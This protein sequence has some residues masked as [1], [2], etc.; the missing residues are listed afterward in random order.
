MLPTKTYTILEKFSKNVVITTPL[1]ILKTNS[2]LQNYNK[3]LQIINNH[4]DTEFW[5]AT[6][7]QNREITEKANLLGIKNILSVPIDENIIHAYFNKLLHLHKVSEFVSEIDLSNMN[8]AVVD[9][10]EMNVKLLAEILKELNV[11][12]Y[13]FTAPEDVVKM[14]ES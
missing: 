4:P 6:A 3:L 1:C 13:T 5:L 12:V 8:V 2:I 7:R 10:N 11:N 9:D 14:L